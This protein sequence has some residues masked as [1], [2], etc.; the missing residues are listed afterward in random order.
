MFRQYTSKLSP[1]DKVC[2]DNAASWR[3]VLEKWEDV[4]K[5]AAGEGPSKH[6]ERHR[7]RGMLSARD[8]MALIL[9][10]ESPFLELMPTA[11]Y[12]IKH[13]SPNAS[14]LCGIGLVHGR[15][16]MIA[17]NIP[18]L[19]SGASNE[20]SVK[21][22]KR[23]SDIALE[24]GLP[25]IYLN[26]SAGANLP[27]QFRVFHAGGAGFRDITLRS[28]AGSPTCTIVFGSSTAGGAYQPG[29][30]S[31]SI[32]V[33]EQAQVFLGGPPLVY[34]ATGEVTTAEDL[35]GAEM[36]TSISGVGDAFAADEFDACQLARNW[37]LSLPEENVSTVE[38]PQ[39][40]APRYDPRDIL[41]VVPVNIRQPM[42]MREVIAR[43]VD[44][45]RFENFKATYG[46]GMLCG[47]ARIHGHLVGI[48]GNQ[49]PVIMIPEA[50]KAT[51]FIRLNNENCNPIIFLHNVTG[52]MVGTKS[53]QNGI[54]RAGSTFIDAVSRSTVP[55]ISILCGASY[56]AGNYA[57][58]GR[59]YAPRFLFSWPNSKCSVMGPEQL[60]GVME[61]IARDAATK[62]G[63]AVDEASISARTT[64]LKNQVEK[65]SDAYTTSAWVLDDGVIDPR[66]TRDVLGMCLEICRNRPSKGNTG[67][68]GVSRI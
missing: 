42:D 14:V 37:V 67:M 63:R 54:I 23:A 5:W 10:P 11:G 20:I 49:S 62:A 45:S 26:Q 16:V 13:S 4:M 21:K 51:H 52:F 39:V 32:F 1:S 53:E 58:C 28:A 43:I 30:S 35:G 25:M 56:G 38:Q 12:N 64:G 3:P 46:P 6:V 57:M 29:M 31:Y 61:M 59:A 65:E 7:S 40:L 27:Q 19:D 9:D 17:G 48:I 66:D 18:T 2:Q 36:H 33:K 68:R 44:D 60:A 24:N 8:R 41:Q 34:V 15:L 50:Q 22:S 47:W 55:H